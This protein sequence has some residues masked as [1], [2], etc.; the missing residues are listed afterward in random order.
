MQSAAWRL[1]LSFAALAQVAGAQQKIWYVDD[2]A[3]P[4]GAGTQQSPFPSIQQAI[5]HAASQGDRVLVAPGTYRELI[6]FQGKTLVLRGSGADTTVL[7]GSGLGWT[8]VTIGPGCGPGTRL[9]GFTLRGADPFDIPHGGGVFC[10]GSTALIRECRFVDNALAPSKVDLGAGVCAVDATVDV[11]RCEFVNCRALN[12][13]GG[14]FGWNSRVRV[15]ESSFTDCSAMYGGGGAAAGRQGAEL[16]FVRCVF[17]ANVSYEDAGGAIILESGSRALIQDSEFTANVAWDQRVGGG[18][19]IVGPGSTATIERTVFS[20]NVGR[21]GAAIFSA[22]SF[23]AS[24]CAFLENRAS[25]TWDFAAGGAI[26]GPGT[27]LRSVF[28]RNSVQGVGGATEGGA[29]DRCFLDRCTLAGNSIAG[30][31]NG[32][33]ASNSTLRN[34]VVWGNTGGSALHASGATWSDIDAP[35]PG[36]G[37]L[38]ADPRFVSAS[39]G[40]LRL[41][42]GSPCIDSGDPASSNDPDGTRADM[43][44]FPFFPDYGPTPVVYCEGKIN[45]EG[46]VPYVDHNGAAASVTGGDF[47]V[48]GRGHRPNSPGLLVWSLQSASTPFQ[49]EKL[50][51]GMPMRRTPLLPSGSLGLGSHC[52]S[53]LSFAWTSAYLGAAGLTAG[54]TIYCQFWGRDDGDPYGSSLSNALEFQLVP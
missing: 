18:L 54:D 6:D 38:S 48:H 43:G 36:I 30:T 11:V 51:L 13:G 50:C 22:S 29:V 15:D 37:N 10:D 33:A 1:A 3:V 27:I 9:V 5:S 7:D 28:W 8:I 52:N 35:T 17:R 49:G 42:P 40:D 23:S 32:S 39:T 41:L 26:T 12:L 16:E 46:C 44:A 19:A 14:V 53:T 2:D 34:C 47:V 4:P 45:S 20:Q 21:R 31:G 24:D 25:S